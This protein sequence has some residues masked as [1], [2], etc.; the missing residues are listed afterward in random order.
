MR[1]PDTSGRIVAQTSLYAI[2]LT[3]TPKSAVKTAEAI[4]TV[5]GSPAAC[6]AVIIDFKNYPQ[7]MPNIRSAKFVGSRDGAPIYKFG[8]KVAAWTIHY[9]NIIYCGKSCDGCYT[10]RWDFV[11]GDIKKTTGSWNIRPDPADSAQSLIRYTTFVETGMCIPNWISD[12][13]TTKTI[14]K[15]IEAITRRVGR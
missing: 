2:R 15:M 10:I 4:F 13:L 5:Q 1:F 9:T 6:N 12:M 14:P 7:F 11:D 3:E 8:F